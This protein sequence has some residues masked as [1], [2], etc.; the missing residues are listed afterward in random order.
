[1]V[2]VTPCQLLHVQRA[3]RSTHKTEEEFLN[4]FRVKGT[5]L[6]RG[7]IPKAV[8]FLVLAVSVS[9]LVTLLVMWW[10]YKRAKKRVK[11]QNAGGMVGMKGF[12]G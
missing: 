6:F 7:D 12:Y 8:V 5:D 10:L 11:T 3:S 1:M 9:E 4:Q 2:A